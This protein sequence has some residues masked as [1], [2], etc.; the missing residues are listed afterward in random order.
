MSANLTHLLT[1]TYRENVTDF[2][3]ATGDLN[4]F[5]RKMKVNL[6]EW[7]YVA[8]AEQQAAETNFGIQGN[9]NVAPKTGA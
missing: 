4:R 5:V 3:R 8:I 1:L 7:L 9:D 6:P 2:K